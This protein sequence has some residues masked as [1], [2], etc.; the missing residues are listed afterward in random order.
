MSA[1]SHFQINVSR[2]GKHYFSTSSEHGQHMTTECAKNMVRDFRARF[3]ESEGFRT[4]VAYWEC[5]GK[6]L[7]VI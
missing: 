5:S 3:P 6:T 1:S 4:E 2:N 7:V